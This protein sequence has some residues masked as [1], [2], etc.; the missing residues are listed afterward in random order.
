MNKNYKWISNYSLLD[1]NGHVFAEI[2][3]IGDEK[4]YWR[5]R[6]V[7]KIEGKEYYNYFDKLKEAK[8]FLED[9]IKK[10]RG[11]K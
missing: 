6:A 5:Y 1:E 8:I 7:F 9:R 4:D 11:Q 2:D 10:Y 3:K